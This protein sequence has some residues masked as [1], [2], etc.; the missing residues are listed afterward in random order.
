MTKAEADR[1]ALVIDDLFQRLYREGALR[2]D[3]VIGVTKSLL[4]I[5][6]KVAEALQEIGSVEVL[7]E[8]GLEEEG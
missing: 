2:G 4:A 1:I 6:P 8:F 3:C 5:S 7:R